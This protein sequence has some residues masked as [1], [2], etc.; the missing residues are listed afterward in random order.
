MSSAALSIATSI[1]DGNVSDLKLIPVGSRQT[2][3]H[4]SGVKYGMMNYDVIRPKV[5]F[6]RSKF[7][8]FSDLIQGRKSAVFVEVGNESLSGEVGPDGRVASVEA[9]F[10]DPSRALIKSGDDED[11]LRFLFSQNLDRYQRS[12]VPFFDTPNP[13]MHKSALGGRVRR[14]SDIKDN[15][16]SIFDSNGDDVFDGFN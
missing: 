1:T 15:Q 5:I 8:N 16:I 6:S 14:E 12:R 10:F 7:G 3:A 2:L 13:N 11:K 9:M 4:P